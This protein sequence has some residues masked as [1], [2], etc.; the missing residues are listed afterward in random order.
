MLERDERGRRVSGRRRAAAD[1]RA[2]FDDFETAL[3]ACKGNS[4]SI[5][6]S[7]S[8][9]SLPKNAYRYFWSR[10]SWLS[11]GQVMAAS[12]AL[13]P[14]TT[15]TALRSISADCTVRKREWSM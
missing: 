13:R 7:S 4:E 6:L 15:P 5:A 10:A 11:T 14:A 9:K 3:Q 12:L 2:A 1:C 8:M